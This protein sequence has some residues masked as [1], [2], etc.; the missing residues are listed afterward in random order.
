M[1]EP[2]AQVLVIDDD[3]LIRELI[4]VWLSRR[5]Y[6][7]RQATSGEAALALLRDEGCLPSIVLADMQLP[8]M[9]GPAL[10]HHL[11]A[12]VGGSARILAM[13][14]SEPGEANLKGFDGFVRKPFREEALNDFL[15]SNVTLSEVGNGDIP[16]ASLLDEAVYDRLASSMSQ[17]K[18]TQ[19]YQLCLDDCGRRMNVIA[20]AAGQNN[21]DACRKEAHIIKGSCGMLGA[22]K[23]A[24]LGAFIESNGLFANIGG[25]LDEMML[26]CRQLEDQLRARGLCIQQGSHQKARR[27]EL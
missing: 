27:A 25:S 13:S 21:V 18:L 1:E 24:M 17:E 14:G 6:E 20:Q 23:I 16:D 9:K 2:R 8:G 22:T 5:G 10:A 15:R 12:M 7:V 11:R 26:A 19:L 4:E 3:A